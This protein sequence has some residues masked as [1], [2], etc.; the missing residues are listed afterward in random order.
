MN[1]SF[2]I[3]FQRLCFAYIQAIKQV[4][5][6]FLVLHKQLNILKY[7]KEEEHALIQR[8]CCTLYKH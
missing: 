3:F 4:I 5:I 6:R 7:L 1:L 8:Q 2:I